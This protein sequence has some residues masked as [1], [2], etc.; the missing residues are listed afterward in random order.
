MSSNTSTIVSPADRI[1]SCWRTYRIRKIYS[2]TRSID[3]WRSYWNTMDTAREKYDKIE[4]L[5]PM[6]AAWMIGLRAAY[7][8][9]N[10][11]DPLVPDGHCTCDMCTSEV[12]WTEEDDRNYRDYYDSYDDGWNE[13][14]YCDY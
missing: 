3:T 4:E 13:S 12:E 5:I 2:E 11:I 14:G 1:A 10:K 7:Y 9:V 8:R 6:K